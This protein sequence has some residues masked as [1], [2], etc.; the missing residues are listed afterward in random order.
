MYIFVDMYEA[1]AVGAGLVGG[2]ASA[3]MKSSN[4]LPKLT[5]VLLMDAA[6]R[7][8]FN[9]SAHK[10]IRQIAVNPSSRLLM[11]DIGA[12]DNISERAWP[13]ERM[14]IWDAMGKD[15]KIMKFFFISRILIS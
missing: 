8:K 4:H 6:S 7:P 3:L 1:I 9:P 13:V 2:V 5:R 12:W 15:L 10:N 14:T 11:E